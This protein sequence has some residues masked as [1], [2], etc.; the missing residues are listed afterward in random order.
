MEKWLPDF[1][2]FF[3]PLTFFNIQ[4]E[5]NDFF[6]S[7]GR[8]MHQLG[9]YPE[10]QE[11]NLATYLSFWCEKPKFSS[12]RTCLGMFVRPRSGVLSSAHH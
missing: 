8:K 10:S 5:K 9:Q 1:M 11:L 3:F 4:W 7:G 12:P 6:S 2:D